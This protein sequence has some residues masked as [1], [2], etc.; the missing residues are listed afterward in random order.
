MG[1][2]YDDGQSQYIVQLFGMES[3][4][5]GITASVTAETTQVV[6]NR[7]TVPSNF[8]G[9]DMPKTIKL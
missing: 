5:E 2:Q 9:K 3:V 4:L 8:R 7:G 1:I 6:E